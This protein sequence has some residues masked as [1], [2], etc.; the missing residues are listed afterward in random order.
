MVTAYHD[1]IAVRKRAPLDSLAVDEHA[2]EAPVIEDPQPIWLADDQRM[3]AGN[4]RIVEADV[5]GEAPAD[6][7][8]LA[9]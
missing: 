1:L 8:P 2:V 3:T 6:P 9:L 5:G 4:R 7:C